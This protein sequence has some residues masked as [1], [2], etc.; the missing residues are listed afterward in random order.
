MD[1][2]SILIS[3]FHILLT[4]FIIITL[5]FLSLATIVVM[6]GWKLISL[7][8]LKLSLV[9]GVE[10]ELHWK[11]YEMVNVW[12]EIFRTKY[13]VRIRAFA[14]SLF[15]LAAH[16]VL[17]FALKIGQKVKVRLHVWHDMVKGKGV[18]K[19][20]GSVSFFLRDIAEHKKQLTIDK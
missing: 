6:M 4:M 12:W 16:E 2:G 7:R 17:R 3:I 1:S 14:L 13:W 5:F 8:A 19:N 18:I 11:F 15:Y 9:E 10:K 20:K